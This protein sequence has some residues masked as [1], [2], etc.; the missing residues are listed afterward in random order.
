MSLA[1]GSPSTG[2]K[3]DI[4]NVPGLATGVLEAVLSSPLFDVGALGGQE[5]CLTINVQR[6]G[7]VKEGDDLPVLLWIFGGGFEIGSTAMYDGAHVV[8]TGIELGKPV[9][10]V[11]MNYRVAGFGFLGG[12][13]ILAD[14]SANL[15]LLDQRLAMQWVADNIRA[16]G[17]FSS[18]FEIVRISVRLAD[19][20]SQAAT[21]TRSLSGARALVRSPSSTKCWRMMETIRTRASRCSA[22]RS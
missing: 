21:R 17:T 19:E 13:E 16:F 11:A 7:G 14:G 15:G 22:G 18:S 8:Q 12:K 6:P 20:R 3:L 10:F 4:P 2:S 1:D 5:D 9:V